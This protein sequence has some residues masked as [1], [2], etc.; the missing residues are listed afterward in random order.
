MD[1]ARE[2]SKLFETGQYGRLYIVSGSHARGSTFRIQVLPKDEKAIVNGSNN[3][4]LNE[5]AV[6]VYGIVSGQPGWTETY[7][8]SYVGKWCEDFDKLVCEKVKEK[9]IE[10]E[11]N[12][13]LEEASEQKRIEKAL[14][15]L[16]DY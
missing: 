2:Y 16:K 1:G 4:C 8:W 6:E 12:R 10:E 15:L 7:G 3:N 5:K 11:K 13:F 9:Q 14:T